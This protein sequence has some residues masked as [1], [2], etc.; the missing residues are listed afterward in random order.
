[1]RRLSLLAGLAAAAAGAVVFLRRSGQRAPRVSVQFE[2]GSSLTLD[3]ASPEAQ[4]L[5]GIAERGLRAVGA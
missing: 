4:R 2:D 1:M 3:P 5:L